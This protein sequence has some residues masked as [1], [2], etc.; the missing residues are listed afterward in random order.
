M[1]ATMPLQAPVR[2]AQPL[3]SVG[4]VRRFHLT[5]DAAL[6][7]LKDAGLKTANYGVVS[8]SGDV[9]NAVDAVG[10]HDLTVRFIHSSSADFQVHANI[11][12][13]AGRKALANGSFGGGA[14]PG[15]AW[16][17]SSAK[18]VQGLADLVIGHALELP[19]APTGTQVP[20][21]GVTVVAAPSSG[22]QRLRVLFYVDRTH[23]QPGLLA[24]TSSQDLGLP[25]LRQQNPDDVA[26]ELIDYKSGLTADAARAFVKRLGVSDG[27]A[28]AVGELLAGAYQNVFVKHEAI[29]VELVLADGKMCAPSLLL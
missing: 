17:A 16:P 11:A 21:R 27:D 2:L 8:K 7:V 3:R 15:I 28:S 1:P 13:A 18:E 9:A 6:N 19:Q 10:S 22:A 23:G 12:G 24:T 25:A 5:P 14:L 29:R 4:A 26:L 20:C